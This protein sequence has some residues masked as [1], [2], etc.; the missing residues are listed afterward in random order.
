M[1]RSRVNHLFYVPAMMCEWCVSALTDIL[2]TLDHSAHVEADLRVR[3]LSVQT[4]RCE[5][6]L[7]RI[8]RETGYPAEPILRPLG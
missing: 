4:N 2:H 8:L 5:A 7:L 6:A 1:Y 3:I